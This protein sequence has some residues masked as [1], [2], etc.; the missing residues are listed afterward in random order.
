MDRV[1]LGKATTNTTSRHYHRSDRFGL[2]ISRPGA[3][4]HTCSDGDLI[5]DST[6]FGIIQRMGKGAAIIPNQ[7]YDVGI[8]GEEGAITESNWNDASSFVPGLNRRTSWVY[9]AFTQLQS[10]LSTFAPVNET[11]E[12]LSSDAAAQAY[13][14]SLFWVQYKALVAQ[15]GDV[16]NFDYVTTTIKNYWRIINVFPFLAN[17]PAQYDFTSWLIGNHDPNVQNS[18]PPIF[19]DVTKMLSTTTVGDLTNSRQTSF[20][21]TAWNSAWNAYVAANPG[22]KYPDTTA[23][24]GQFMIAGAPKYWRALST[25]GNPIINEDAAMVRFYQMIFQ[26]SWLY[27][28]FGTTVN[29]GALDFESFIGSAGEFPINITIQVPSSAGT[30]QLYSALNPT[31]N[32]D[33]TKWTGGETTVST[34]ITPPASAP[35]H[36]WWQPVIADTGNTVTNLTFLNIRDNLSKT[37]NERE[38]LNSQ[39]PGLASIQANTYIE[40]NEIKINFTQPS[41]EDTSEVFFTV[42]RE[43][44]HTD[45]PEDVDATVVLNITDLAD[46]GDNRAGRKAADGRYYTVV[47]PDDFVG[48]KGTDT[49]PFKL[50][51]AADGRIV[52]RLA[53]TLNIPEN[54]E[55]SGNGFNNHIT[56]SILEKNPTWGLSAGA[57]QRGQLQ[58]G[59][60]DSGGRST[61]EIYAM[62]DPCI[63]INLLKQDWSAF[64]LEGL[65]INIINNG[66]MIGAGGWGQYGQLFNVGKFQSGDPGGGGGGG[67]GYH[68]TVPID[69]GYPNSWLGAPPTDEMVATLQSAYSA[70]LN[71][72]AEAAAFAAAAE[73]NWDGPQYHVEWGIGRSPSELSADGANT[74]YTGM[75][76]ITWKSIGPGKPGTGYLG[77]TTERISVQP[78]TSVPYKNQSS[79]EQFAAGNWSTE[80]LRVPGT[81]YTL[82]KEKRFDE[83]GWGNNGTPGT[84]T[85]PGTGGATKNQ[86]T[87]GYYQDP[88]TRIEYDT[89]FDGIG[90]GEPFAGSGGSCVFLCS[91]FTESVTGTR[92]IL[93]NEETGTIKSGGGGGSGGNH[94]GGLNGGKLGRPGE[95]PTPT[96]EGSI[97]TAF[98]TPDNTNEWMNYTRRGEPGKIVWWGSSAITS[99]YQIINNAPPRNTIE[100]IEYNPNIYGEDYVSILG[101][102]NIRVWSREY[103]PD[104]TT[105]LQYTAMGEKTWQEYLDTL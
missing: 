94:T 92:I 20:F 37:E 45:A 48:T 40:D 88:F 105:I 100:G 2:F 93:T 84:D 72:A 26:F 78:R 103:A 57:H 3:N 79:T 4:V 55:L 96:S 73:N 46:G 11:T 42:F 81:Y 61:R 95:C 69:T 76:Y 90:N 56:P 75:D 25:P 62:V 36:V 59:P 97:A 28:N 63:K 98:L 21:P 15:M 65:T 87:F 30:T 12:D 8:F 18:T 85:G 6:A 16:S 77:S 52:K 83:Q 39:K 7:V 54:I 19:P 74:Y 34:G 64:A 99:N 1:L 35:V 31:N 89:N 10:E 68:P 5:F 32:W 47:F 86:A 66:Q 51:R 50:Y 13:L 27:N 9:D 17:I 44:A 41:V 49:D 33:Y 22:V 101:T 58:F 82:T 38:L 71:T 91:D 67:Q 29:S 60:V 104:S 24:G 70:P 80:R 43:G 53:V 102:S 14:N 23:Y